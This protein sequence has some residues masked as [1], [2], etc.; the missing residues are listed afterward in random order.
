MLG[1]TLDSAK[2]VA[3][4]PVVTCA[5]ALQNDC[6]IYAISEQESP[7][8]LDVLY[9]VLSNDEKQQLAAF[10]INKHAKLWGYT[11]AWLR[12]ILE[13]HT[14]VAAS[15]LCFAK[16]AYGKPYI[17]NNVSNNISNNDGNKVATFPQFNISHSEQRAL[18]AVSKHVDIGV[19]IEF[20]KPYIQTTKLAKHYFSNDETQAIQS[21]RSDEQQA[22]F[23]TCWSRKEAFIKAMGLGLSMPLSDF[24]VSVEPTKPAQLLR[25][26]YQNEHPSNWCLHH[27]EVPSGYFA[28]VALRKG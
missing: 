21:L 3:Q 14:Q 25:V 15:Q 1:N 22:A 16:N 27:I 26:N 20:A 4:L 23:F 12:L 2:L 6:V 11:H 13:H 18:I 5:P 19:D 17:S 28:A 9:P 8:N 10:R 24:S 7:V